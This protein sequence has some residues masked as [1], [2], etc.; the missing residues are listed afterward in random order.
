VWDVVTGSLHTSV[1]VILVIA[2]AVALV[3]LGLGV[4]GRQRG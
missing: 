4:A 3:R 1:L 2:A